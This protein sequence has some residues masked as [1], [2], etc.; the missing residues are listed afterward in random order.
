MHAH[1]PVLDVHRTLGAC[2]TVRECTRELT[3][4]CNN[5]AFTHCFD[6]RLNP[7]AVL[8]A[9]LR[10]FLTRFMQHAHNTFKHYTHNEHSTHNA[11]GTDR[12]SMHPRRMQ[13]IFASIRLR[14]RIEGYVFL[15]CARIPALFL[16]I[17]DELL[18]TLEPSFNKNTCMHWREIL[19]NSSHSA[20]KTGMGIFQCRCA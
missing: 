3:A 9:N 1:P 13:L 7:P 14:I 12:T 10:A 15:S 18:L 11:H 2:R 6:A 5:P 8:C 19:I 4:V 17:P 20:M 16:T